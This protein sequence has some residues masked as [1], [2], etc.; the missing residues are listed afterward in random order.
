MSNQT[1]KAVVAGATVGNAALTYLVTTGEL[2][3]YAQNFAAIVLSL[4]VLVH[5]VALLV[6]T[7]RGKSR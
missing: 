3:P 1:T 7:L 2:D 5:A 6:A 4:A